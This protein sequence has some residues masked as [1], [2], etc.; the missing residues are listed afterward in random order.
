VEAGPEVELDGGQLRMIATGLKRWYGNRPLVTSL[1][2]RL[3]Y[4]KMIGSQWTIGGSL[5]LRHSA[6]RGNR[7]RRWSM[8]SSLRGMRRGSGS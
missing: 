5:L 6:A 1:G 2:G 8:R 3:D 4:D 7:S